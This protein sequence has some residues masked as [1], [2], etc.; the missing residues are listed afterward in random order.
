MMI[1]NDI[2]Y[3]KLP[4]LVSKTP[5]IP[6]PPPLSQSVSFSFLVVKM[7]TSSRRAAAVGRACRHPRAE[8][9]GEVECAGRSGLAPRNWDMGGGGN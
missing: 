8:K 2:L 4:F 3:R 5:P 1:Y 6:G 7:R 9:T